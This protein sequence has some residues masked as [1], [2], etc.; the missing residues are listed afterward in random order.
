M[1]AWFIRHLQTLV[2]SL[3]ELSRNPFSTLLSVSVIAIALALP[4]GL[5]ATLENINKFTAEFEH[6]A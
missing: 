4:G 1:F 2:G 3:G 6:G 5:F